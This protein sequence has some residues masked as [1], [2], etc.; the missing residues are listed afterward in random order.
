MIWLEDPTI[1]E[2]EIRFTD[3][4]L[5]VED[6]VV[7]QNLELNQSAINI[8]GQEKEEAV[9]PV[10]EEQTSKGAAIRPRPSIIVSGLYVG[11]GGGGRGRFECHLRIDVDGRIPLRKVSGDFY[12]LSGGTVTYFGSFVVD[13]ITIN[14][15][16]SQIIIE[17]AGTFTWNMGAPRVR[18]VIQR[19]FTFQPHAPA[20]L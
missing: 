17:G 3:Q 20:M 6:A 9:L 10:S 15:T 2:S 19:T 11:R 1:Q 7:L 8:V 13:T 14:L 4:E 5:G 12:Q 16:G 18:I